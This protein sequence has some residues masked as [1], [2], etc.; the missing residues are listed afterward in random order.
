MCTERVR[1]REE[2][3]K[4]GEEGQKELIHKDPC[5][6]W[7]ESEEMLVS[8]KQVPFPCPSV[9]TLF[10][11]KKHKFESSSRTIA[12]LASMAESKCTRAP[13]NLSPSVKACC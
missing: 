10:R 4:K 6:L 5:I 8:N 13:A 9:Y 2:E 3:R 12:G 7:Q 1:S 11:I